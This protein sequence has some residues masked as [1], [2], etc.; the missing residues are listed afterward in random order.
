MTKD[1]DVARTSV[2]GQQLILMSQESHTSQPRGKN[3][4]RIT[5][6]AGD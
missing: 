5:Q 2:R 3:G 6:E 4:N 1:T